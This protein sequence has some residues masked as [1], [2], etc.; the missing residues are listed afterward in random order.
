MIN[1]PIDWDVYLTIAIKDL[2]DAGV[3]Y[4]DLS[5]SAKEQ[6]SMLGHKITLYANHDDLSAF[7][8]AVHEWR[9]LMIEDFKGKEQS[10]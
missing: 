10:T 2:S 4:N 6:A 9:N 1:K 7:I 3:R 8:L 5:V